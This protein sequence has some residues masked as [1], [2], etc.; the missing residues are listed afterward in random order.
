MLGFGSKISYC[1]RTFGL[2]SLATY[3]IAIIIDKILILSYGLSSGTWLKRWDD[4][5]DEAA[6][7]LSSE[8]I[9]PAS[10]C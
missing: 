9:R 1:R 2:V 7:N 3:I 6:G 10:F 8:I 5:G 4:D